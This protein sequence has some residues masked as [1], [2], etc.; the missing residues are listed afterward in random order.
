VPSLPL[1]GKGDVCLESDTRES[2]ITHT[3]SGRGR[4]FSTSQ[5]HPVDLHERTSPCNLF[6]ECMPHRDRG[7]ATGEYPAARYSVPVFLNPFHTRRQMAW[8]ERDHRQPVA[9][10]VVA[11][12]DPANTLAAVFST[13]RREPEPAF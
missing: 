8:F 7:T 5:T 4:S 6:V 1:K 3:V 9:E 11:A 13:N 2:R 12:L 10:P